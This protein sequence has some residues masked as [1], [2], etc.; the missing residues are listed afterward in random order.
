MRFDGVVRSNAPPCLC[1][2]LQ[3]CLFPF[4]HHDAYELPASGGENTF[5]VPSMQLE[6]VACEN[7]AS[8]HHVWYVR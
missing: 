5:F 1:F 2:L 7:V 4:P 6:S 8:T 3:G